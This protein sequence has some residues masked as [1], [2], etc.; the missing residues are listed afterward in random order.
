MIEKIYPDRQN[1]LD[2]IEGLEL[3]A[4]IKEGQWI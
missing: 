4:G 1:T 3:V 2:K